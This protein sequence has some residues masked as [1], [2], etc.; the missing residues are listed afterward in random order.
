MNAQALIATSLS[1]MAGLGVA[2]LAMIAAAAL[3]LFGVFGLA[4]HFASRPDFSTLYANL[5][6][7][8]VNA[9]GDALARAGVRFDVSADGTE[10]LVEPSE[11]SRAR[12]LL[13][14][15][16]LPRSSSSG[17]EL[18]DNAGSLGLTS[19]MQEVTLVRALEGE[20]ARTLQAMRGVTAARVHLVLPGNRGLTRD[21]TKPTA[22]V[23]IRTDGM[24]PG[25][26][27]RAI[28]HLVAAA[29]PGL[30]VDAVTVMDTDGTLLAGGAEAGLPAADALFDLERTVAGGIEQN[31]RRALLPAV[32]AD[33]L[34]ISVTTRLNT[35]QRE[36]SETV[37]DPDG[38]VERSVRVSRESDSA[39]NSDGSAAATVTEEL[40]EDALGAQSS[41]SSNEE[42]ERRDETTEYALSARTTATRS[43]GYRIEALS[44]AV[45]VN[46]ASLGVD[47]TDQAAVDAR[48][49]ELQAV[50]LTAAGVDEKR[51]DKVMMTA[52]PFAA[53]TE[54]APETGGGAGAFLA[55]HG[56]ILIRSAVLLAVTALILGFAVRP[57][58]RGLGTTAPT[59]TSML[60][61]LS[62]GA[63]P[64][65]PLPGPDPAADVAAQLENTARKRLERIIE[66]DEDKAVAVLKEWLRA[67]R[68]GPGEAERAA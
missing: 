66:L 43:A 13:A 39:I 61:G 58:L 23:V 14:E 25:D 19:F 9:M 1:R 26:S 21:R 29:V 32:G 60:E 10:M 55:S 41:T 27:A 42:S 62:T 65:L 16:G 2:R 15:Q 54:G 36:T 35:D 67:G 50:A 44:V 47:A 20:I 38:R 48:L 17:Y 31:I 46:R 53:A 49:A 28:R 68:D 37:Y 24:A 34:R 45:V 33:N 51:G 63:L 57:A 40:P 52:L 5:D 30:T 8:D 4:L 18:F 22:S 59:E 11:V 7:Q 56:G 64:G 3:L 6:R 12:M